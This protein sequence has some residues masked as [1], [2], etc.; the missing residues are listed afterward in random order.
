VNVWFYARDDHDV[1]E[2]IRSG[3]SILDPAQIR[4]VP[5]AEFPW[6]QCNYASHFD[7]H[8]IVFDLTFCASTFRCYRLERKQG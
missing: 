7:P 2:V 5:D 6:D 1:P 8:N 3:G 4:R